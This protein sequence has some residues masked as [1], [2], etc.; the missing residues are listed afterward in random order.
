MRLTGAPLRVFL[1]AT[2]GILLV[3]ASPACTATNFLDPEGPRYYENAESAKRGAR[4]TR[5]A[6]ALRLVTFNLEYGRE[7]DAAI[8]LIQASDALSDPD[9]LLLQ[10]MAG[11]GVIRIAE[12]LGF[13]YLYYPSGIHP[14]ARQEFGT[15]ILSP[16]PI[17]NPSKLVLPHGAAFTGLRRAATAATV[18]WGNVPIRV[19]SMHL[20]SPMAIGEQQRRDQVELVLD[21]VRQT[22]GLVIV[23]GDFNSRSIG[24][25]FERDGFAWITKSIP[26][27][28]RGPG[29]WLSYDH[30][31]AARFDAARGAWSA[32]CVDAP[33]VSDHRAVWAR[34]DPPVM[35]RAPSH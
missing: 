8:A 16:W 30:V 32:G 7:V 31:F 23:A 21:S 1:A 3:L 11:A 13:N 10:E 34:L 29:M 24:P 27:T 19:Y 26:G 15:A 28:S 6:G 35:T 5:S 9:I 12:A 17:V 14:Q 4:S 20:P 18:Q 22:A 33:G 25:R 2:A